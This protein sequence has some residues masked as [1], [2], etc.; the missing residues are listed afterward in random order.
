MPAP[1]DFV[2]LHGGLP[3][4][5]SEGDAPWFESDAQ[6]RISMGGNRAG[7][8]TKLVLEVGSFAVGIRPW[9]SPGSRWYTRGLTSEAMIREDRPARI[10]YVVP[11]FSVHLPEVVAAFQKWWPKE[12]WTVIAKDER[13]TPRTF[14]FFNGAV[15]NFMSHRMN[16]E[17][18]EGI[19]ADLV[20][21][22]EPP[23]EELFTA[24][25]RGLVSTGGRSITGAT[26][27]DASGWFWDKVVAEGELGNPEVLVTW[28][29]IWDN[30]REN[31]SKS[32]QSARNVLIWLMKI[33]DP[34][35]RLAREHG[36][37]MH[38]G[39]LILKDF[40]ADRNLVDP[41][42]LPD[43]CVI[44]SCIDPAGSKPMAALHIAY[45]ETP[46][47]SWE[48]HLFDETYALETRN[49]LDLFCK[50]FVEKE[51]GESEP[52][53]PMPSAVILIDPA[54]NQPQK[55]DAAGRT[56]RQ[57]LMDRGIETMLADKQNKRGRL[58]QLNSRF[59]TGHYKVWRTVRRFMLERRRWSWDPNSAKLTRG[60][61][62]VCDCLAY[63][64]H[65]DPPSSLLGTVEGEENGVWTPPEHR[66]EKS[67]RLDRKRAERMAKVA[68]SELQ[69]KL[70]RAGVEW[71]GRWHETID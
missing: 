12:W 1:E 60:P 28:H 25:E 48:G 53:H 38:V 6:A 63:I 9:Y 57:I 20:A 51:M 52:R 44:V 8:T 42:P 34:D 46:E 33:G 2:V 36:Y 66:A 22:D 39:G 7:K 49:D 3:G 17:D 24:L 70:Q 31:G 67:F 45:I 5:R 68:K 56:M 32:A 50:L 41:F 61:D 14:E 16:K 65:A 71:E 21:W 37:P 27:L 54:A 40:R 10:R 43:D 64:D 69:M 4:S 18:F 15:V 29:S 11:N 26:L 55:A 59:R 13:N 47:G 19:E 62:D 35:E 23:P 30:T 58:L